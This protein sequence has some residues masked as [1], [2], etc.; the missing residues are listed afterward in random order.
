M[1]LRW[2]EA[3]DQFGLTTR[4]EGSQVVNAQIDRLLRQG[5]V[6]SDPDCD[7]F[8]Q[9]YE[10]FQMTPEGKRFFSSFGEA[11]QDRYVLVEHY[12]G[13]CAI[14]GTGA[15][16]HVQTLLST[17]NATVSISAGQFRQD[18]MLGAIWFGD[19]AAFCSDRGA[20][21]TWCGT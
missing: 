10:L 12:P 6:V 2:S 8:A 17:P 21:T 13:P 7:L 15:S 3:N 18:P 4:I 5:T 19:G 1:W 11:T 20:P 14:T 16:G 9:K